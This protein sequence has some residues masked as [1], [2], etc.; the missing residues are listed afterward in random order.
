MKNRFNDQM[1]FNR[2]TELVSL[3]SQVEEDMTVARIAQI[4]ET[5]PEQTRLDLAQ[6]HSC[7]LRISPEDV[8]SKF[9]R[10]TSQYDHEPLMLE[11]WLPLDHESQEGL[12]FFDAIERNLFLRKGIQELKIKNTPSSVSMEVMERVKVIE[13]ALQQEQY[14]KF[15]YKRAGASTAESIETAPRF[16]YF[17]A[18]DSLYYCISFQNEEIVPFRLDRILYEIRI[19]KKQA[20][21]LDPDDSRLQRLQYVWGAAF[22][23]E[24]D[25]CHVKIRIKENTSN[26]LGKIRS[27]IS[28]RAHAS[29]YQE[30]EFWYYEDDIIGISSFRSWLMSFGSSVKAIEPKSLAEEL[31]QSSLMRLENYENDN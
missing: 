23:M 18:T 1:I 26:I 17:N 21:P 13:K 8:V 24:E 19:V 3:L 31:Y 25:P 10:Y 15:R 5:T 7:G 28:G 9:D 27:D 6:L 14:V 12:L 29:L 20:P 22:S 30:N 16:L 4:T 11:T 2:I